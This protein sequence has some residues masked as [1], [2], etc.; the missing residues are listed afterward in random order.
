METTNNDEIPSQGFLNFK[1]Y[2]T[3]MM[4]NNYDWDLSEEENIG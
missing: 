4:N 1:D 2:V 3:K